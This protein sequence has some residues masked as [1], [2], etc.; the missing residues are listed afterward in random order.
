MITQQKS[1]KSLHQLLA[2]RREIAALGGRVALGA[3]Y[4]TLV[5][6]GDR[7]LG[8]WSIL[9]D[10]YVFRE[11]SNY[12]PAITVA[13]ATAAVDVTIALLSLCRQGWAE[14]FGP[15]HIDQAAA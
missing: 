13:S 9:D 15:I 4:G 5:I 11:L 7:P 2:A 8:L 10:T 1:E 14:R 12:E 3:H 6:L